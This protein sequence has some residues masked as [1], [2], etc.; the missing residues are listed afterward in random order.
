M[1]IAEVS[2][3]LSVFSLR[4]KGRQKERVTEKGGCKRIRRVKEDEK[5]TETESDKDGEE[6]LSFVDPPQVCMVEF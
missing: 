1:L 4:A 6:C 3:Y 2:I 5:K